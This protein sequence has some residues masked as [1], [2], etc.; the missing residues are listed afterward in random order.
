[1]TGCFR[2]G[3]YSVADGS[4][5]DSHEL[6]AGSGK[7]GIVLTNYPGERP[8]L[9][10]MSLQLR[11]AAS[12]SSASSPGPVIRGL[13]FVDTNTALFNTILIQADYST[14]QGSEVTT[15]GTTGT[16]ISV[17]N[18]ADKDGDHYVYSDVVDGTLITSNKIHDCGSTGQDHG[19]YLETAASTQIDT[20]WIYRNK[21]RGVQLSDTDYDDPNDEYPPYVGVPPI[22]TTIEH[23]VLDHNGAGVGARDSSTAAVSGTVVRYNWITN[24]KGALGTNEGGWNVYFAGASDPAPPVGTGNRVRVNCLYTT[25]TGYDANGGIDVS[26][27][28]SVLGFGSGFVAEGNVILSTD[29]GLYEGPL[30][31]NYNVSSTHECASLETYVQPWASTSCTLTD[32]ASNRRFIGTNGNDT[33]LA[34]T[35]SADYLDGKAGDD[36]VKAKAGSDCL[37]GDSGVDILE[38]STGADSVKADVGPDELRAWQDGVDRLDCG[39]DSGQ[40]TVYMDVRDTLVNC[41]SGDSLVYGP[42]PP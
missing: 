35:T 38:P 16:C 21:G 12:G 28:S 15:N 6:Y 5:P 10:N 41:A 1:M 2:G 34:G 42:S 11:E 23:N 26:D 8:V 37:K 29:T 31:D 9:N 30:A 27:Y 32:Y 33:N 39:S 7:A 19:I 36:N 17:D 20:N 3:D 22:D 13:K 40:D 14:I 24:S 18:R 4:D 25:N